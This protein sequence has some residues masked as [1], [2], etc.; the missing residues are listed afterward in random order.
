[1][2]APSLAALT[3]GTVGVVVATTTLLA[4]GAVSGPDHP[5][6][7]DVDGRM[8]FLPPGIDGTEAAATPEKK[9]AATTSSTAAPAAPAAPAPS[10]AAPAPVPAPAPTRTPQSGAMTLAA[11]T[12]VNTNIKGEP[13]SSTAEPRLA[14]STS[15]LWM[16]TWESS[17]WQTLHGVGSFNSSG[18]TSVGSYGG[19]GRS[20]KAT[21]PAG[22]TQGFG[23]MGGFDRMGIGGRDEVYYRYRVYFPSSYVWTNSSGR[24]GG[25]LPGLAGK[26]GGDERRVGAG[27]QRWNDSTEVSRSNLSYSDEWSARVMWGK[28]R[29]AATYLYAQSPLGPQ[30]SKSYFGHVEYCRTRPNDNTSSRVLFKA[31]AWNTV[32]LRVKMNT[33]GSNNGIMQLWLNGYLCVD[34]RDV[35]YR[36]ARRPYLRTTQQYVTWYYGG[37]STDA[38]NKTSWLLLDDAVLSRSYIG[39]RTD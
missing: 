5:G 23:Y 19:P 39:P 16:G 31:G 4:A 35:Q 25:K 30:S 38:P 24:G 12:A 26:D 1:M 8:V 17:S 33:P 15:V 37:P 22:S 3:R 14:T 6:P 9:A 34:H 27:G 28:D 2:R 20:L 29:S 7:E 10:S 36:S 11:T 13:T 18:N 21:A 32:E